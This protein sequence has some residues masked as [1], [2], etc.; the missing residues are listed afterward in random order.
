M[1]NFEKLIVWQKA[2]DLAFQVYQLT[3]GFPDREMYGITAQLR[4]AA[5]SIPTNIAEGSGRQTKAETRRFVVIAMGSLAETNYLLHFSQRLG[6]ISDADR[7]IC[8]G[9][10]HEVGALLWLFYK[11]L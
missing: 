2:D 11:S 6:L 1:Q 3:K 8:D 9:L 10:K 7:I 4:R 5:L